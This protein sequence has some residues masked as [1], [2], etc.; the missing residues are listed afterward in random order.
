MAVTLSEMGM[1]VITILR[2][3]R[4]NFVKC[5]LQVWVPFQHFKLPRCL[6]YRLHINIFKVISLDCAAN[7]HLPDLTIPFHESLRNRL[8]GN[9]FLKRGQNLFIPEQVVPL[10]NP[11]FA[12]PISTQWNFHNQVI[13]APSKFSFKLNLLSESRSGMNKRREGAQSNFL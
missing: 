6:S 11:T 3:S 10:Y 13:Q 2:I 8:L 9:S 1:L 5:N 4:H 12:I 7:Q